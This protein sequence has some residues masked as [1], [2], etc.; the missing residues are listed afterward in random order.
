MDTK[1]ELSIEDELRD[2]LKRCPAG[3]YEAALAFRE[4]KDVSKIETIVLGIIDRHLEPEQ[5]EI[6]AKNRKFQSALAASKMSF[7]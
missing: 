7:A 6:L 5:R 4:N 3:T 2:L 1:S